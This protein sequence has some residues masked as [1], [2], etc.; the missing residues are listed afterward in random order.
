MPGS[1]ESVENQTQVFHASPSPLKIPQARRDF[2]IST[3]P[4]MTV[5]SLHQRTKKRQRKGVGRDAPHHSLSR[6]APL[7][8]GTDFMLILQLEN[9]QT[10]PRPSHG[11]PR[12][13][14]RNPRGSRAPCV[15]RTG[16][17]PEPQPRSAEPRR[18]QRL[19]AHGPRN[20]RLSVALAAAGPV[21]RT[22]F[23]SRGRPRA[24]SRRA[25][26]I[27][28]TKRRSATTAPRGFQF[29]WNW[30]MMK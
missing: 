13:H 15:R 27:V 11:A 29:G 25:S 24:A 10:T 14:E 6:S 4:A 1:V 21:T 17:L 18:Q 8:S 22:A 28:G 20:G 26:G 30:L 5:L 7:S 16:V 9:A 2:H 3:A 23:A 19:R 12:S